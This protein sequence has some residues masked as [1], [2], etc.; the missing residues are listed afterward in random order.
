[1]GNCTFVLFELNLNWISNN[2]SGEQIIYLVTL[3]FRIFVL[4]FINFLR[5]RVLFNVGCTP[6][7]CRAEAYPEFSRPLKFW[8]GKHESPPL[9][10]HYFSR[11][12]Y[13]VKV[14]VPN[15]FVNGFVIFIDWLITREMIC[16]HLNYWYSFIL[17][18]L[19]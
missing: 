3:N 19:L 4:L 5:C 9:A 18:L 14:Q 16:I 7:C 10:F 13:I 15:L 17:F 6:V 8:V 12:S 1:M 2:I 11:V